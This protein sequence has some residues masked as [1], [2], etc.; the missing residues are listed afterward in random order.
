MIKK[1]I[2][3]LQFISSSLLVQALVVAGAGQ[4]D[5]VEGEVQ[6]GEGDVEQGIVEIR[7]ALHVSQFSRL[8]RFFVRQE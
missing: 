6:E 8:L 5:E 1:F 3:H 4:R 7:E 2:S